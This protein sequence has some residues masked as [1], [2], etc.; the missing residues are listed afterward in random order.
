MKALCS[1]GFSES[2]RTESTEDVPVVDIQGVSAPV[3]AAVLE[4]L[5]TNGVSNFTFDLA[6]DILG[7]HNGTCINPGDRYYLTSSVCQ[8]LRICIYWTR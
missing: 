4:F 3:M 2:L 7:M 8:L 1:G 5:Y 6:L